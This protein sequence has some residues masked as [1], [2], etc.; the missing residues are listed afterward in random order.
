M[1]ASFTRRPLRTLTSMAV[2]DDRRN[3][4]NPHTAAA[5]ACDAHASG[6]AASTAPLTACNHDIGVPATRYTPPRTGTSHPLATEL[7]IVRSPTSSQ[8]CRHV[9]SPS[10]CSAVDRS[11]SNPMR[12]MV[13]RGCD[14]NGWRN[15]PSPGDGRF[16]QPRRPPGA[17]RSV[18]QER[19]DLG[20]EGVHLVEVL[21]A[22]PAAEAH[23]D[24]TDPQVPQG[25]H[26]R[27]EL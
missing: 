1:P 3:P 13:S 15:L 6:P 8:T 7:R 22:G 27:G 9:T 16:R 18:V 26:R 10:W 24:V 5:A 25:P 14:K 2:R 4:T 11:S 12:H 17:G 20:G 23:L 19:D 21:V